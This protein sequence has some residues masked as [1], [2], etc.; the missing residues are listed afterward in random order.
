LE[1]VRGLL[2]DW[3]QVGEQEAF[4]E[5]VF[6]TPPRALGELQRAGFEVLT[7]AGAEGFAARML[8]ELEQMVGADPVAYENVLRLAAETCELP[9]YRD[10]TEHLHAVVRKPPESSFSLPAGPPA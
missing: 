3:V 4:T 7:Y 8:A 10:A 1:F 6:L 5:A 9:Q 2:T